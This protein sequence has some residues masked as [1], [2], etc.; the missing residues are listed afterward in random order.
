M[1][2]LLETGSVR[3]IFR[4]MRETGATI[5]KTTFENPH[6]HPI[7]AVIAVLG[8]PEAQEVLDLVAE[9]ERVWER[10][11]VARRLPRRRS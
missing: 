6:G 1:D 7:G 3:D 9:Q 4:V 5:F 11:R 10:A 2:Q 8:Q